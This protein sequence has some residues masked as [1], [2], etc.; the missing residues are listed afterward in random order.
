MPDDKETKNIPL[1]TRDEQ[2]EERGDRGTFSDHEPLQRGY[3]T[4]QDQD[5]HWNGPDR[6]KKE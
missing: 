4:P 2:R 5:G 1:P 3:Q 6:D